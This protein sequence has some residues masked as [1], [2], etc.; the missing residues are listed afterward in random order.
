M[1]IWRRGEEETK[2]IDPERAPAFLIPRSRSARRAPAF[3]HPAIIDLPDKI[4][5]N[6]FN[7]EIDRFAFDERMPNRMPS[8]VQEIFARATI[9]ISP[10]SIP[11]GADSSSGYRRSPVTNSKSFDLDPLQLLSTFFFW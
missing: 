2:G 8:S 7:E 5:C 4:S 1:A 10:R 6:S 9:E 11:L 3:K